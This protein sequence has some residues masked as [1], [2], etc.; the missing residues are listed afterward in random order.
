MFFMIIRA[1]EWISIIYGGDQ[2]KKDVP[3]VLPL[4]ME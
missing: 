4:L 2:P 3:Q 1:G